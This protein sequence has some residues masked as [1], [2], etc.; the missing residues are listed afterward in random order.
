MGT[1]I[2]F[3]NQIATSADTG[4]RI[5]D[6]G[7]IMAQRDQ[8]IHSAKIRDE[9]Q[10]LTNATLAL[11]NRAADLKTKETE[12]IA[13]DADFNRAAHLAGYDGPQP[14]VPASAQAP[15]V[16]DIA[17]GVPGLSQLVPQKVPTQGL[18]QLAQPT[19][20]AWPSVP[21]SQGPATPR[22][23]MPGVPAPASSHPEVSQVLS[24]TVGRGGND[25]S[26]VLDPETKQLPVTTLPNGHT[27]D[28]NKAMEYAYANGRPDI[29]KDIHDEY[30]AH[31]LAAQKD[32][33]EQQIKAAA[34]V[35]QKAYSVLAQP[36][37]MQ[38]SAWN[39]HVKDL[40]AQGVP[41]SA[42]NNGKFDINFVR[43]EA[44]NVA[45]ALQKMEE[46]HKVL[47]DKQKAFTAE[48]TA[49][50]QKNDTAIKW[51]ELAVKQQ[52]AAQAQ[53][54]SPN[55]LPVKSWDDIPAD[56]RGSLQKLAN[57]ELD[58]SAFPASPR[59]GANV[60]SQQEAVNIIAQLVPGWDNR[61]NLQSKKTIVDFA[62]S[63]TSGKALTSLNALADH[64]S[65]VKQ[66]HDALHNG[67]IQ[68]LNGLANTLGAAVGS[69]PVTTYRTMLQVYA[70]EADKFMS[71]GNPTIQG[72]KEWQEK[73]S[74]KLSPSQAAG[75]FG[76]LTNAIG[77]KLGGIDQSYHNATSNNGANPELGKHLDQTG[78]LTEGA[79][80]MFS[81]AGGHASPAAPSLP[82]AVY[83]KLSPAA[84]QLHIKNGGKVQ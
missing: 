36:A 49:L 51:G 66:A 23:L 67:N 82:K 78:L 81:K 19:G 40:T 4:N 30:Y 38:E 70:G 75:S 53:L 52:Q 5:M 8:E 41:L 12:R 34:A 6:L 9:G 39:Q 55:G 25:T 13:A 22:E 56:K 7:S 28:P 44:Q 46:N 11:Q 50:H 76:I 72:N 26:W 20:P 17:P 83:D 60:V 77:G 16:P 59:K 32:Q 33:Q 10:K 3:A 61:M 63:G 24:Q 68:L 79:K 37:N 14:E 18:A 58:L 54:L 69:D 29:A 65:L 47:E 35:A 31:A 45:T 64:T 73:L 84:Q 42:L 27:Y 71:G 74:D 2:N 21:A 57:G 43:T 62:P 1:D 15:P 48:A 80:A